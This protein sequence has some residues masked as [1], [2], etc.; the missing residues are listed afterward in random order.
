M[1]LGA[2]RAGLKWLGPFPSGASLACNLV[3]AA[4]GIFF[5]LVEDRC[6]LELWIRQRYMIC[7]ARAS[8]G[9]F[10]TRWDAPSWSTTPLRDQRGARRSSERTCGRDREPARVGQRPRG[11]GSARSSSDAVWPSRVS[12]RRMNHPHLRERGTARR[13][14]GR[15]LRE[16]D[17]PGLALGSW[18]SKRPLTPR[19][20][21]FLESTISKCRRKIRATTP[22]RNRVSEHGGVLCSGPR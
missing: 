17:L 18:N 5:H 3:Q 6:C 2:R 4:G 8:M 7:R 10:A 9:R 13:V 20:R 1:V 14:R 21:H 16:F 19:V 22:V 12:T 15:V 11:D